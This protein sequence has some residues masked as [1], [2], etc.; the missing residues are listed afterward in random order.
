MKNFI[1]KGFWNFILPVSFCLF[2]LTTNTKAQPINLYTIS[3]VSFSI[4]TEQQNYNP[5]N[6]QTLVECP[7][8][9]VQFINNTNTGDSMLLFRWNFGDGDTS[10]AINPVHTFTKNGNYRV[11]LSA[12][13]NS[14][15]TGTFYQYITINDKITPNAELQVIPQKICPGEKVFFYD[16]QYHKQYDRLK[17]SINFGDGHDTVNQV[18]LIDNN[19]GTLAEHVYNSTGNYNYV[20]TAKNA[21][22]DSVTAK[23]TIAVTEVTH[24]P[25][26]YIENSTESNNNSNPGDWSV[27]NLPGDAQMNIPVRWADFNSS[28]DSTFYLFFFAGGMTLNENSNPSGIVPFQAT[29]ID[30]VQMVTAYIPYNAGLDTVGIG[31][32]HYCY[33]Q[34][35]TA[36]GKPDL[37]VLPTTKTGQPIYKIPVSRDNTVTLKD[38]LTLPSGVSGVCSTARPYYGEWNY[39]MGYG[40]IYKLSIQKDENGTYPQMPPYIYMGTYDLKYM[41][42]DLNETDISNGYV[43]ENV[44]QGDS[45]FFFDPSCPYLTLYEYYY[46]SPTKTISFE[47]YDGDLCPNRIEYLDETNFQLS[48]MFNNSIAAC[49]NSPVK[50]TIAGGNSNVIWSFGDSISADPSNNVIYHTYALPG[51]YDAYAVVTNNC[52]RQDT[53]HTTVVISEYNIPSA[54]IN[55]NN[56]NLIMA[57]QPVQF[58][59]ST[60]VD[61]S[62]KFTCS[63]TFGDSISSSVFAP[64]HVYSKP[65]DYPV[66]LTVSNGCGVNNT[67]T[68]VHVSS[69]FAPNCSAEFAYF[70]MD[71]IVEFYNLTDKP[72]NKFLW[73]FGDGDTSTFK[74]PVHHFSSMT[75]FHTV[76]LKASSGPDTCTACQTIYLFNETPCN[77]SFTYVLNG[78]NVN[79]M[80]MMSSTTGIYSW[81]FGDGTSGSGTSISHT[82][83]NPGWYR[84]SLAI[85]APYCTDS[86][87]NWI[88]VQNTCTQPEISLFTDGFTAYIYNNTSNKNNLD[89]FWNFGDGTTS[90]AIDPPF[91]TFNQGGVYYMYMTMF[92][93]LTGCKTKQDTLLLIGSYEC[94]AYFTADTINNDSVVFNNYSGNAIKYLWDFGD[95]TISYL[96]NPPTKQYSKAGMYNVCLTI[97]DTSSCTQSF[98]RQIAVGQ[99]RCNAD[100]AYTVDTITETV[101]FTNMSSEANNY[102][103]DFGDGNFG[104]SRD[105]SHV[106][107]KPGMYTVFLSIWNQTSLCYN[108]VSKNILVAGQ[109]A[110][111]TIAD[112][113]YYVN[114]GNDTVL[115]INKSSPNI[116]NYYWTFGDGSFNA[117]ENPVKNYTKPGMYNVCLTVFDVNSGANAMICKTVMVGS[118]T[119]NIT[120]GMG[121][122]IDNENETVHFADKSTG[123]YNEYYWTFGDGGTSSDSAPVKIYTSPGYYLVTLAVRKSGTACVD[124]TADFLQIGQVNC[125]ADFNYVVNP[126]NDSVSFINNSKG[127]IA[128]YY[129]Y[130]SDG[131][132]SVEINPKHKFDRAGLYYASLTV[133]DASGTCMDY[134]SKPIQVGDINCNAYFTYYVDIPTRTTWFKNE[135]TGEATNYFWK[136]GDGKF[137]TDTNP[138]HTF[139]YPGYYTIGLNVYNT[140]DSC[141]DYYETTVLIGE[142]GS[143]CEADF[144]YRVDTNKN[145]F[146]TDNSKG[147]ITQYLWDFG[148]GDTAMSKN[149]THLYSTRGFYNVCLSIVNNVHIPNLICKW[150]DVATDETSNCK[151]KFFFIADT[152]STNTF[153]TDASFG[154]PTKW[155]WNFG[156]GNSSI[157]ENPSHS[158]SKKGYYVTSLYI[159]NNAGCASMDYELVS[160]GKSGDGLLADFGYHP[161]TLN[162]AE[163]YPV[164]FVGV[165]A[166]DDARL[167]WSFGDGSYDTTSNTPHHVY[168]NPGTYTVCLT[169]SDPVT[170]QQDSTCKLVTVS[171]SC[172]NDVTK[173]IAKCNNVTVHLDNTGHVIVSSDTLTSGSS[174]NCTKN[175][176]ITPPQFTYTATGNHI[177]TINVSDANGNTSTCQ[178]TITVEAALGINYSTTG[179]TFNSSPNPFSD[180][181]NVTYELPSASQVEIAVFD[182]LG[183]KVATL[184]NVRQPAGRYTTNW[185]A[186]HFNQGSYIIQLI[187]SHGI[188][189]QILIKQ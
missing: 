113:D 91:H 136:F 135:S 77:A 156:D 39:D 98:C 161:D 160:A 51:T 18:E 68:V 32:G 7:N 131:G 50:F 60:P 17:Y 22:N 72:G 183:K 162:K 83:A 76:C 180:H 65:G 138:V 24:A 155:I 159:K 177:V 62:T 143:D 140:A 16:A 36:Q 5:Q 106:Y 52:L 8:Q 97:G 166:G 20:F 38:T 70:A 174:D 82:Y 167:R 137:S 4:A 151:A 33:S 56:G 89:W 26:Y 134:T 3:G 101:T 129:W 115:F 165:G 10:S 37:Y 147:T 112:F 35:V 9:P 103:W 99:V 145:V 30:T 64:T 42:G 104:F 118:G 96:Q 54:Q 119:C 116:T 25:M 148:D 185:D 189:K 171:E 95:G 175:L 132:Y 158:Y 186:T 157:E 146:F 15:G 164:D 170:Q 11:I 57:G 31:F 49:P 173:P 111:I 58:Q 92:D 181:I 19:L 163:G 150:I 108:E 59:A 1:K 169:Y 53:I 184:V 12:V 188:M 125:K 109:G 86:T 117:V 144:I 21:C 55:I 88:Q 28:M 182:L 121:Y 27:R 139:K 100:F 127:N 41:Q 149:P 90:N 75:Y 61:D 152:L 110:E 23:G 122:E 48:D 66:S 142:Q 114:A 179:V 87:S 85:I 128:S 102:F 34:S 40:M 154:K 84:V 73:N 126:V 81:D 168:Q 79:F 176:I 63:W 178:D 45:L 69:T 107:Q 94:Y 6:G 105:T 141:M 93:P 120:A 130:F 13:D 187:T 14:G 172:T 29:T 78:S 123:D 47:A 133:S 80:S 2:V 67:D 74:N 46:N 124:Y 71:T 153:F 43:Y 44:N